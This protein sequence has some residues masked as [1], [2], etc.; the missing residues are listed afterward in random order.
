MSVLPEGARRF[1]W[2]YA[3]VMSLLALLDV[4]ALGAVAIAL[5]GLTNPG[6]P[7]TVPLVGWQFTGFGQLAVL[8]GVFVVL[9]IVKSV[10][11]LVTI[12]IATK[13]FAKHEVAIGEMLFRSY[14][15]APWV[16]RLSK[17]SQEIIRM[18]DSGVAAVVANVLMPSMTVISEFATIAVITVGLFIMDW[19]TALATMIYLGLVALVMSRVIS[20][21]A[22]RNGQVNRD[23]SI[24]VV[25]LLGEVLS[26]L[27]EITL[28]GNEQEVEEI[29]SS[30]RRV[31]ADTRAF[32]QYYNQLPRFVLEAGLV[33]GRGAEFRGPVRGGRVPPGALADPLPV[34]PEPHPHQCG[35]LRLDHRRHRQRSRERPAQGAS[36]HR[37]PARRR[38]GHR[39]A[40]RDLHLPEPGRP[41]GQSRRSHHSCR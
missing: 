10:L 16:D 5:P 19:R 17:S 1:L 33:G 7:V 8:V 25:Q 4:V 3:V 28:K 2:T 32:A 39:P 31:A 18:V 41:R 27:K 38:A 37:R 40:G 15:S 35:V 26:S 13:R 36:R 20:P 29:V 12:R 14:M 24:Q 21:L 34:H 11:N 30:R 22:V 9:T 23:N 6:T